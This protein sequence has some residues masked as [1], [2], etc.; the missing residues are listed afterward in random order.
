MLE[1]QICWKFATNESSIKVKTEAKEVKIEKPEPIFQT[2]NIQLEKKGDKIYKIFNL[3]CPECNQIFPFDKKTDNQ[4]ITCPNC[5][6]EGAI[7][8]EI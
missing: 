7:E 3:K 8:K 6:K 4:K 5:G 2:E 1:C